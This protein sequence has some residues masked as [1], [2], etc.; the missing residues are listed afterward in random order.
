LP[1]PLKVALSEEEDR[2]LLEFQK[3]PEVPQ[4]V[5]ERAEIVRLNHYGWSVAKIAEYKDK[6]PHTIRASLHRGHKQG[7]NGLWE[8]GNRGRKRQWQEEDLQYLEACLEQE[9]RTYNATQLAQ[10]LVA[11][12]GVTLSADR[13]R[14]LLKKRGGVGKGQDTL[15]P[16]TQT[17]S[18]KRLNKPT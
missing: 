18:T 14:K 8:G 6:S 1:A 12:R 5:K 13:L 11:E 2:E 15:N 10:K 7:L 17:P 3:Q 9:Q 16:Y 4:R